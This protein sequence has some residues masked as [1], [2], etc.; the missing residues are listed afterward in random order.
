MSG[1]LIKYQYHA[2][3]SWWIFAIT[4]FGAIAITLLTVSYQSLKAATANPVKSLRSE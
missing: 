3:L 4:A 1:W 2:E